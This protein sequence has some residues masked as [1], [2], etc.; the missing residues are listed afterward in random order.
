MRPGGLAA[1]SFR[2][3]ACGDEEHRGGVGADAAEA[4]QVRS[5]GGDERDDELVGAADLGIGEF[6][7][8]DWFPQRDAKRVLAASPG[9]GRRAATA[10]ARAAARRSANRE[11]SSSGPVRIRARAWLT[12]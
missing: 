11:R 4:E 5:A 3:V 1:Q 2:V 8:A 9:R 6:D 10:S 7:A 12:A